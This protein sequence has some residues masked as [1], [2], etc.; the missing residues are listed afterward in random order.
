MISFPLVHSPF[1]SSHCAEKKR[2]TFIPWKEAS[3]CSSRGKKRPTFIPWK[4]ASH[5]HPVERSVPRSSRG[6]KR[7]T[8]IPCKGASHLHH[9]RTNWTLFISGKNIILVETPQ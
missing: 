2:P 1:S 3:P 7:P 5:V 8:F 6:K 9:I 4:E